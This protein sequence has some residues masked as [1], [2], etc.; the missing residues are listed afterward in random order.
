MHLIVQY[1]YQRAHCTYLKT[2]SKIRKYFDEN[3]SVQESCPL[4]SLHPAKECSHAFVNIYLKTFSCSDSLTVF[5]DGSKIES[6]RRFV[7]WK[8]MFS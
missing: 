5:T 1:E 7:P 6:G 4:T 2:N 8:T 3:V